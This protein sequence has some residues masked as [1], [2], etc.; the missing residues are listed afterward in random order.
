MAPS[1]S[2]PRSCGIYR[3]RRGV[4]RVPALALLVLLFVAPVNFLTGRAAAAAEAAPKYTLTLSTAEAAVNA[5]A[6]PLFTAEV[7][8]N[9]APASGQKIVFTVQMEGDSPLPG[10]TVVANEKGRAGY[11]LKNPGGRARTITVTAALEEH[12]AVTASASVRFELPE[13]FLALAAGPLPAGRAAQFCREQGGKLPRL[14][15]SDSLPRGDMEKVTSIEGFGAPGAPWPSGLPYN[16]YWTGTEFTG[17]PAVA[18]VHG[19]VWLI[20]VQSGAVRLHN[21]GRSVTY[22]VVCVPQQ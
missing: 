15:G 8:A 6:S 2:A 3:N 9:G 10:K 16:R 11:R 17:E 1:L 19:G 18:G 12:P 21:E 20:G 14:N 7:T 22:G 13:G 4:L 5:L